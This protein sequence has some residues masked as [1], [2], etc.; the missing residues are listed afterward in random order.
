MSPRTAPPN[1]TPAEADALARADVAA[2]AAR[3]ITP[4]SHAA[5]IRAIN[6][7]EAAGLI[8]PHDAL[9]RRGALGPPPP[10][11]AP[12]KP[13]A[14]APP[15]FAPGSA[16]I[17]G[18]IEHGFPH[19]LAV[20]LTDNPGDFPGRPAV[21]A[22]LGNNFDSIH[23]AFRLGLQIINESMRITGTT[24]DHNEIHA[25]QI[26][27]SNLANLARASGALRAAVRMLDDVG[28]KLA[29]ASPTAHLRSAIRERD[30][31]AAES[32]RAEDLRRDAEQR[33]E[34]Q[35]RKDHE[36]HSARAA[37]DAEHAAWKARQ[38]GGSGA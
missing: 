26:R 5:A 24:A 10:D 34:E 15:T 22:M 7:G 18:I 33:A 12:P 2:G 35:A 32:A 23:G 25:G 8:S 13:I 3:A 30:R 31:A 16:T 19:V 37:E 9:A 28:E 38:P 6:E 11:F 21:V 36:R 29:A 14:Y 20:F 1:I 17:E 4:D 27:N